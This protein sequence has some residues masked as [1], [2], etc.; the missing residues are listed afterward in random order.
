MNFTSSCEVATLYAESKFIAFV[1]FT[2]ITLA[3]MSLFS[4]AIN[5]PLKCR[6]SNSVALHK[7]LKAR[8]NNIII[9]LVFFPCIILLVNLLLLC[10]KLH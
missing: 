1:Q 9:K 2:Q 5:V 4:I 3:I 6:K 10:L 7:N 8:I